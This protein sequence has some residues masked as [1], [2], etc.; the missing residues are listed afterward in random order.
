M[1]SVYAMSQR[2]VDIEA[3]RIYVLIPMS[4]LFQKVPDF[5]ETITNPF[6]RA[7]L[8]YQNRFL[9]FFFC[10][11]QC[12][13]T[14]NLQ[15]RPV[16]SCCIQRHLVS[17]MWYGMDISRFVLYDGIQQISYIYFTIYTCV[18]FLNQ[19][20]LTKLLLLFQVEVDGIEN[21]FRMVFP[22]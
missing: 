22:I 12:A 9:V 2:P 15:R 4:F 16:H 18:Q 10:N 13:F 14:T 7:L 20:L 19:L 11:G 21:R 5:L 17:R 1:A 6:Q 3:M 8:R